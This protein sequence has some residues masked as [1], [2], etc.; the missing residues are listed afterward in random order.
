M[1]ELA[2]FHRC[3]CTACTYSNNSNSTNCYVCNGPKP[4]TQPD[5]S[6]QHV[7][8]PCEFCDQLI[9]PSAYTDHL[10]HVHRPKNEESTIPCEK[11]GKPIQVAQYNDHVASHKKQTKPADIICDICHQKYT[12]DEIDSHKIAHQYQSSEQINAQHDLI[13]CEYAT[14]D[15][16]LKPKDFESHISSHK[17]QQANVKPM[18]DEIDYIPCDVCKYKVPSNE[19]EQHRSTC[20]LAQM[21]Q[22][23]IPCDF[24]GC[25]EKVPFNELKNHQD[26]HKKEEEQKTPSIPCEYKGC[27][28]SIP[29]NELEAHQETHRLEDANIN[30]HQQLA[31]LTQKQDKAAQMEQDLKNQI[32]DFEEHKVFKLD[33]LQTKEKEAMQTGKT[34]RCKLELKRKLVG[35]SADIHFRTC[36][37]QFMRSC[38][39]MNAAANGRNQ[40]IKEVE[41]IY[42]PKLIQ[43]FETKK[44]A[45]MTKNNCTKNEL[46][47]VLAWHGTSAANL[48][49]IVEN[50]FS[51]AKLGA[52]TGDKGYYGAGIYFSEFANVSQ[53]YGDALLLCK[54]MLGKEYQM[55]AANSRQDGRA[56]EVGYDSHVVVNGIGSNNQYGQEVVI[57]D[58]DQVLPCYIVKH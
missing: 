39:N 37:S 58:V 23:L 10:I 42:N 29:I 11:C 55:N 9:A 14:C 43:K 41:Y 38:R 22:V 17:T 49:G 24:P 34:F 7:K 44:K 28:K 1:A 12:A 18:I 31:V 50:N 47:I 52:S 32:K 6:E 36:E 3:D 33:W 4:I 19:Y 35:D 26:N 27:G 30:L 57:Y 53:G 45:L 13:P 2:S 15:M 16:K 51:L 54:V 40:T 21:S 5:A 8:I 56:L 48:D 25:N 46:N 20:S